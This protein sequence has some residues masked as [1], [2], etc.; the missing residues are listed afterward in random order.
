VELRAAK[1]PADA[2][3][4][5]Q[6]VYDNPSEY[7]SADEEDGCRS[8]RGEWLCAKRPPKVAHL[9]P[10]SLGPVTPFPPAWKVDQ[11]FFGPTGNDGNTCQ[12]IGSPC[13]TISQIRDVRLGCLGSPSQCPRWRT[14]AKSI[15]QVSAETDNSDPF[16]L[17]PALEDGATFAYK[18]S[19]PAATTTSTL[20]AAAAKNRSANTVQTFTDTVHMSLVNAG[21]FI[22]NTGVANGAN[23]WCAS[24]PSGSVCNVT[25]P[26]RPTTAPA[27]SLVPPENDSS[28]AGNAFSAYNTL[29]AANIVDIEPTIADYP[30]FA[31]AGVPS[32]YPVTISQ[33]EIFDPSG[34]GRDPM[35]WG[36]GVVGVE[37]Q[38]DRTINL[39]GNSENGQADDGCVNCFIAGGF[40]GA[41]L[42]SGRFFYVNGGILYPTPGALYNPA[43][44]GIVFDGDVW[45][46]T[47]V[48]LPQGGW[49]TSF[50]AQDPTG[51][52][53]PTTVTV[54]STTEIFRTSRGYPTLGMWGPEI[55]NIV[56]NV[57]YDHSQSFTATNVG[58][59]GIQFN[60][61]STACAWTII[62]P[63]PPP[64]GEFIAQWTC[65]VPVSN[66]FI[67]D[68][69]AGLLDGGFAGRVFGGYNGRLSGVP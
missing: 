20:T 64:N 50:N 62:N 36:V 43:G 27:T 23:A 35:N 19:L 24:K 46:A 58:D 30:S 55:L 18:C 29:L 5:T 61:Q 32:A 52:Q 14:T 16:Y 53:I 12:S 47:S 2:G 34:T 48:T 60:G 57:L 66:Y 41:R 25:Q 15:T 63:A 8:P 10:A 54:D 3:P 68:N 45:I 1:L 69:A 44:Q 13:K 37:I 49:L 6:R 42:S 39:V 4:P 9:K 56:G 21:A 22:R 38:T 17:H 26:L 31:D 59:G 67:D 65:N 28:A 7:A 51:T 33:C 40:T 11:W